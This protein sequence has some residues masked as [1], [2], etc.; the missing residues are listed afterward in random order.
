MDA[1]V[2]DLDETLIDRSAAVT[3]L[4]ENL[5][6]DFLQEE[7]LPDFV[8]RVHDIDGRGYVP[9]EEFFTNL[10][11]A[12]PQLPSRE[13]VKTRFLQ[14]VWETPLLAAGTTEWLEELRRR[15]IHCAIVSNGST[16]AQQAKISGSGIGDYFAA[17]I[18][19]EAFGVKKPDASIYL[20][21]ASQLGVKPED[22]WFVGDHPRNDI[23]GSKQVGYRT[24]WVHLGRPWLEE[25][26]VCYD[27][28]GATLNETMTL[29]LKHET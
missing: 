6:S 16:R 12:F 13:L 24:A 15:G 10:H 2:F 26:P 8:E 9:R 1:I 29:V 25:L 14:H 22:S 28:A 11:A 17:I 5:W 23:W 4:A 7:P 18:V 3:A 21:A 20:A 27:V 19:S